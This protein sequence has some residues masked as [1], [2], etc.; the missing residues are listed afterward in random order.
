MLAQNYIL[1]TVIPTYVELRRHIIEARPIPEQWRG[2]AERETQWSA[3]QDVARAAAELAE[4]VT[5]FIDIRL[6]DRTCG[7][8][9]AQFLGVRRK[10]HG[11]AGRTA[12]TSFLKNPACELWDRRNY[13][14]F[15]MICHIS[16]NV[17]RSLLHQLRPV[18]GNGARGNSQEAFNFLRN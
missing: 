18:D 12:G 5:P 14:L 4:P 17:A 11:M 7:P 10:T 1:I 13:E 2:N 16:K 8:L 6:C 3:G 9:F 15:R